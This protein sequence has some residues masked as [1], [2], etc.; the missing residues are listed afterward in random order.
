[1]IVLE[2]DTK[3]NN[4]VIE[5]MISREMSSLEVTNTSYVQ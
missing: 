1:M 3:W 2:T 4:E 5:C